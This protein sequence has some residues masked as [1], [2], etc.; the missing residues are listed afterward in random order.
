[1]GLVSPISQRLYWDTFM[2]YDGVSSVMG[3]NKFE[4]ILRNIHFVN[5]L[6]IAEEEKANDRIWKLRTQITELRQNF[7]RVSPEEFHAVDEIMVPFKGKSLLRRYLPKKP[8]KWGFKLWG[9]SGISGFLYDFGIY[10]GKLKSISDTSL[11]ISA[12][13]VVNLTSSL[14]DKHK[15]KVFADNY[16]PIL[17]LIVELRSL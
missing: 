10:Q 1:M 12:D 6:E 3:R 16:F 15:F 8:H 13:V 2:T 9:R 11:G 4:T 7:L 14:P 5:N 17:P